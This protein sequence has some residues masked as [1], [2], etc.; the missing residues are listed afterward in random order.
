MIQGGTLEARDVTKV[1]RL[2]EP[3]SVFSW[4]AIP[5]LFRQPDHGRMLTALQDVSFGIG[6]GEA[7]GLLGP[8]GTGKSTLLRILTGV[9]VPTRGTVS[10]NGRVGPVLELGTGFYDELTAYDNTFLNAQLLGMTRREVLE[11]FDEIFGFAELQ[12]FVHAP[13]RQFSFGMRLRLA[14]S[15]AM[16]LRPEILLLDEVMGVGDLQFQRRS[17][18][19]IRQAIDDGVTLVVVSHHLNDLTRVCSRG[20]L[21][22]QGRLAADGPIQSVID[23][24]LQADGSDVP[25]PTATGGA[26]VEIVAVDVLNESGQEQ[27]EFRTGD[28]ISLRMTWRSPTALDRPVFTFAIYREDGL[29]LTQASTEVSGFHTGTTG[30]AGEATFQWACAFQPGGYRIT[31]SIADSTARTLLAQAHSAAGFEIAQ[32]A[33][34]AQG[35]VRI[36][37]QWRMSLPIEGASSPLTSG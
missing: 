33:G 18:A 13:M 21:L 7:V 20:L 10:V 8:N 24:Y 9:T 26:G 36:D 25:R 11:R 29:F 27:A 32:R 22:R 12:D 5:S 2:G 6:A 17:A 23:A 19:R 4:R 37:G 16:A 14:F 31:A 3:R 35:A 28:A 30:A 1:Y 34:A 15:I